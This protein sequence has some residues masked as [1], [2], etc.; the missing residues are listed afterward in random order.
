MKCEELEERVTPLSTPASH[1][2]TSIGWRARKGPKFL[3]H[4]RH[5][6]ERDG[7]VE[8][9]G[10]VERDWRVERDGR[11]EEDG[12]VPAQDVTILHARS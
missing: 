4:M 3:G 5:A 10:R 8:G 1:S 12:T 2:G 6:E 9:D 7:R 11:V